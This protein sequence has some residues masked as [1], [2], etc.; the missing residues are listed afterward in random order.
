V[1]VYGIRV[2]MPYK[3]FKSVTLREED[4]TFFMD[5]WEKRKGE[6]RKKGIRSFSAFITRMLYEALEREEQYTRVQ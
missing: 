5:L 2:D 6:L 4:Y 3:G 1:V